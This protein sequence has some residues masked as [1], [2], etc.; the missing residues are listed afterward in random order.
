MSQVLEVSE[1]S[2]FTFVILCSDVAGEKDKAAVH[3]DAST[4]PKEVTTWH[5]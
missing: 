4:N 2:F 5:S 3:R 1:I